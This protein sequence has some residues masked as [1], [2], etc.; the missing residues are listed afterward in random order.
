MFAEKNGDA[1]HGIESPA[2]S[3]KAAARRWAN[4]RRPSYWP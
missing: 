1:V 2:F 3:N 4:A